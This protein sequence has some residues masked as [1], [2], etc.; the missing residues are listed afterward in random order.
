MA[1]QKNKNNERSKS[2]LLKVSPNE[3]RKIQRQADKHFNGNVN[4]FLREV[5]LIHIP[6]GAFAKDNGKS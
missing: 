3:K 2:I 1:S 4:K 6:L 5:A